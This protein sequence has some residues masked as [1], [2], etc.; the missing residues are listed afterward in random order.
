[1]I[2]YASLILGRRAQKGGELGRAFARPEIPRGEN[3]MY[4]GKALI[5][6]A[7]LGLTL[8]VVHPAFS[9]EDH[10]WPRELTSKSASMLVYQ[11]Q[12]E[13][14]KEFRKLEAKVVVAVKP[15]NSKKPILGVLWVETDT[16]TDFDS[17]TVVISDLKVVNAHF[18][19]LDQGETAKMTQLCRELL[20]K[21]PTPVAL[22][23]IL[24]NIDRTKSEAKSVE[25]SSRP[26]HIFA[27]QRPAVLVLIEGEP[28]LT[29]IE[30]TDLLYVVNTNWPLFFETGE[31]GMYY[32]LNGEAWLEAP[33]LKGP[34]KPVQKLPESF[35]KLPDTAG[36]KDVRSHLVPKEVKA[37]DVPA[38]FVSTGPAELIVT[39]GPPELTPIQGTTLFV[40]KNTKNELFMYGGDGSYYFLVAG[41]WLRSGDL[42]GPWSVVGKELPKEFAKL[43][44]DPRYLSVLASVPG[45]PEAESAVL[46]AQIPRTATVSRAKAK[47][48][49][50]YNGQ[51]QFKPIQGTSM[52]YA[53]NTAYDVIRVGSKYYACYQGVWFVSP[54]P[55]GP[56][57]VS[58]YVPKE[59]Y[60]IP[61]GSPLFPVTY[62]YVYGSTP[63]TVQV[64][65]TS[66]YL[67]AYVVAGAVVYGTG[68]YYPPYVGYAGAVPVYYPYPQAYGSSAYYNPYT[69]VYARGA[70]VSGPYG[71]YAAGG[72]Y[73]PNTGVYAHG[74]TAWGPYGSSSYGAA[75]NP[76]TGTYAT[77]HQ[78]SNVYAQ[79]GQSVVTRGSQSLQTGHYTNSS[80]TAAG[81]RTSGGAEGAGYHGQGGHNAGVVKTANDNLYAGRD[82]NVYKQTDSGW[83]KYQDG[84]WNP[85]QPPK[86]GNQTKLSQPQ[87]TTG[88]GAQAPS[89]KRSGMTQSSAPATGADSSHQA[90]RQSENERQS[91]SLSAQKAGQSRTRQEGGTGFNSSLS[92]RGNTAHGRLGESRS[93]G[94]HESGPS[95]NEGM[96]GRSERMRGGSVSG[97]TFA[98]L[99]RDASG[100]GLGERQTRAFR[101]WREREGR[102]G[103]FAGNE[104]SGMRG[105]FGGFRGRR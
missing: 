91:S 40:V 15:K 101:D 66:G 70:S 105:G 73:N 90:F 22:D 3:T 57:L 53:V 68:Y 59:I 16:H 85:V 42:S 13:G 75:Y 92:S 100:R 84:S 78:S 29:P 54:S 43:P 88:G 33:D 103:S 4:A 65:Y 56:W 32:L 12:V 26:P 24:A 64:G 87:P 61:P 2:P 45:T 60:S 79:W 96:L 8:L 86:T 23:R 36:W 77:T 1:M 51:P 20:P 74:A 81:F 41:R 49:V 80:G 98:Q 58:A 102:Q 76:G 72:F 71:G 95:T 44:Q 17:R 46:M 10:G 19:G 52:S 37:G 5:L 97:G 25:A 39:D 6:T 62:V 55:D 48:D 35:S 69:G 38:V 94:G 82:G 99:Q 89:A 50:T 28:V 31:P 63:T 67:G 14:W 93:A 7:A 34:W 11:P 83:Y 18:P 21:Q 27:S 30:K 47:V 9:Q 104:H